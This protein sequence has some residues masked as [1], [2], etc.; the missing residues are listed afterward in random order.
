MIRGS[1]PR[2]RNA[3]ITGSKSNAVL[4]GVDADLYLT[5]PKYKALI[6]TSILKRVDVASQ[7]VVEQAAKSKTFDNSTYIGDLKNGGVGLSPFHDFTTKIPSTLP[8]ELN[9]I[10]SGIQD[11]SI[12]V[13]SPSSLKK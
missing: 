11:G 7:K 6:L 5:D 13:D 12:A 2:A 4:E 1:P 8:A 3:A 10:K 9:T